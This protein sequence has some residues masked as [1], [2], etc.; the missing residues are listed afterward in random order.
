VGLGLSI[1]NS[2]SRDWLVVITSQ[3]K[4]NET[5]S[6]SFSLSLNLGSDRLEYRLTMPS[7]TTTMTTTTMMASNVIPSRPS[8]EVVG[9][10]ATGDAGATSLPSPAPWS[11]FVLGKKK[12]RVLEVFWI[13]VL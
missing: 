2:L 12:D 5:L 1:Y 3:L 4:S 11:F 7:T 8:N 6:L 10:A 9:A 13:W